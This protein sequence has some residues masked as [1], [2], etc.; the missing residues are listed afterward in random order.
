MWIKPLA[1]REGRGGVPHW[2]RRPKPDNMLTSVPGVFK[3]ATLGPILEP[4]PVSGVDPKFDPCVASVNVQE[5][6]HTRFWD[7]TPPERTRGVAYQ[8]SAVSEFLDVSIG[9]NI[10][11][12]NNDLNII[13]FIRWWHP[14]AWVRTRRLRKKSGLSILC[15]Y[16]TRWVMKMLSAF[17]QLV[18]I[19]RNKIW[20]WG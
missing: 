10:S 7:D 8:R 5:Q 2:S 6:T 18:A 15:L 1:G 19:K 3:E 12:E 20:K 11:Q 14:E 16:A 4:F 13:I 17:W 9:C